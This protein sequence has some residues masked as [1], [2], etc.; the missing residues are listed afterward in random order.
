MGA[1]QAFA[2]LK[3]LSQSERVPVLES[4]FPNMDTGMA[5]GVSRMLDD[6][7][8][9]MLLQSLHGM[10]MKILLNGHNPPPVA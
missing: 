8:V 7:P 6:L 3:S 1:A 9:D 4:M 2:G 5:T 10:K